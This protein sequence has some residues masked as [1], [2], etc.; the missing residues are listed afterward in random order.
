[1]TY[2]AGARVGSAGRADLTYFGGGGGGGGGAAAKCFAFGTRE[3]EITTEA[4]QVAG[5]GYGLTPRNF[6]AERIDAWTPKDHPES[7]RG[8]QPG[9]KADR[10]GEGSSSRGVT[11]SPHARPRAGWPPITARVLTSSICK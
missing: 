10:D 5:A 2:A 7:T 3:W 11:R 6:P 4:V 8:N 1:L 9:C